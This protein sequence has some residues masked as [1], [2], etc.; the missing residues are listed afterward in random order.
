MIGAFLTWWKEQ[1][2]SL[3][4]G[5]ASDRRRDVVSAALRGGALDVSVRRGGR[6]GAL[7]TFPLD[8][9]GMA[10]LAAAIGARRPPLELALPAG[11][12][13][14]HAITLPLAAERDPAAVLRFEMDRLTPFAANEL[15]WGWAVDRRDRVRSQLQ[16]H[17][18]LVLRGQVDGVLGLLR[19]AG[20]HPALLMGASRQIGLDG[21]AAGAWS[22]RGAVGWA[23]ACAVLSAA[24]IVIPFVQQSR[25]EDRIEQQIATRRP[26]VDR[27]EALRRQLAA[28][29][30]VVDVL[31]SQRAKVGDP[32]AVMAAL[33]DILP[34]DTVLTELAL[35][36]RVITISGASGAAA[37]LIAA[38]AADP[39]IRDP[40]FT[41]PV[42]R[43]ETT[44]TDGF[45]IRA[46]AASAAETASLT[47]SATTSATT[48]ATRDATR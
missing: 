38:L 13:L 16:L 48:N 28:A 1:L 25:A 7:G 37:R 4:P 6:T 24:A 39:A 18:W 10:A 19:G 20:L 31:A 27:A 15:Y 47:K 9:T 2:L 8:A 14:E 26:A 21:A 17:L 41:A 42:T 29:S 44:H 46:V 43:N 12:M 22:R 11:M 40:A 34:D 35:R 45:S 3:W 30:A 23:V 36:Q 32:L 33:T 5:Q